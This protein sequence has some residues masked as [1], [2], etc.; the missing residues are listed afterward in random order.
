VLIVT[1]AP[2]LRGSAASRLDVHQPSLGMRVGIPFRLLRAV[3]LVERPTRDA[4]QVLCGTCVTCLGNIQAWLVEHL[5][6]M[7][8][9]A[10]QAGDE[11]VAKENTAHQSDGRYGGHGG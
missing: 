6:Q 9:D 10:R 7:Q 1:L 4:C 3:R 8:G 2:P 5:S 11:A